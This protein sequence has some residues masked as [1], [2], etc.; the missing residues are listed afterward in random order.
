MINWQLC[1]HVQQLA[2]SQGLVARGASASTDLARAKP[3]VRVEVWRAWNFRPYQRWSRPA[4]AVPLAGWGPCDAATAGSA[5]GCAAPILSKLW[6][7]E[8]PWLVT[9]PLE[10]GAV[11]AAAVAE[12]RLRTQ[13]AGLHATLMME[14]GARRMGDWTAALPRSGGCTDTALLAV[15]GEVLVRIDD[16]ASAQWRLLQPGERAKLLVSVAHH[17]RPAGNGTAIWAYVHSC[18]EGEMHRALQLLSAAGS[19]WAGG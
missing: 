7:A 8:A 4:V 15:A 9:E 12:T 5:V 3:A 17:V 18:G 6:G 19:A 16:S 2:V 14:A 11:E 1:A 10:L 13:Q